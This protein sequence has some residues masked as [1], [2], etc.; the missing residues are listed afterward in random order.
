MALCR[1]DPGGDRRCRTIVGDRQLSQPNM[2]W[3]AQS[4]GRDRDVTAEVLT[5]NHVYIDMLLGGPVQCGWITGERMKLKFLNKSG[6]TLVASSTTH[7]LAS[8]FDLLVRTNQCSQCIGLKQHT[9]H[10]GVIM[11]YE[12]RNVVTNSTLFCS[13]SL[14]ITAGLMG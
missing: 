4:R 7:A 8:I 1:A 14:R 3:N 9:C 11:I 5:L 6:P 13:H 12:I 2:P 10:Q